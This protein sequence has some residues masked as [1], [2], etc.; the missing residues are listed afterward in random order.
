VPIGVRIESVRVPG[1]KN[2]ARRL[3]YVS[4]TDIAALPLPLPQPLLP[5]AGAA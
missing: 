2:A 3:V 4:E 1:V 5:L